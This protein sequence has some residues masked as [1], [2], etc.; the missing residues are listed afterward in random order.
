MKQY[1]TYIKNTDR[2]ALRE[3]QMTVDELCAIPENE[4]NERQNEFLN[5]FY[6]RMPVGMGDC[7]MNKICR[8]FEDAFDG[9]IGKHNAAVKFDYRIM[10]SDAEYKSYSNE[11]MKKKGWPLEKA[12]K[13]RVGFKSLKQARL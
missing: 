1:N 8:R 7:V 9:Y 5:F 2:N 13:N 11:R 3:F 12:T 4:R 6:K 10:R